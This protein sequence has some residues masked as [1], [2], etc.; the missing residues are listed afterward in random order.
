[1]WLQKSYSEAEAVYQRGLKAREKTMGKDLQYAAISFNLGRLFQDTERYGDAEKAY[2]ETAAVEEPILGST[3]KSFLQTLQQ[4]SYLYELSGEKEKQAGIQ[5]KIASADPLATVMAHLPKNTIGAAAIRPSLLTSD[6]GLQMMP[7]EVIEATGRQ[8]LGLNPFDVEAFVAFVTLPVGEEV[9][10]GFLFKMKDGVQA[11]S[12]W[13]QPGQGETI[14]FGDGKSY[15]KL[16]PEASDSQCV[17]EYSDGS[18]LIGTE[19]SIKQSLSQPGGGSVGWNAAGKSQWKSDHGRWRRPIDS[20]FCNGCS[21]GSTAS[22]TCF[23]RTQ[24]TGC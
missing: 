4:L 13:Q 12:A 19:E 18:V 2:L 7:F 21:A 17:V 11:E 9:N 6:P 1:M 14:E 23:G 24:R 8:Q 22:T 15:L 20:W 10:F 3:N 16:N 5:K